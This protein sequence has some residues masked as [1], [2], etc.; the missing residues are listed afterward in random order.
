[1]EHKR[2][3]KERRIGGNYEEIGK[4]FGIN[5]MIARIMR[6]RGLETEEQMQNFLSGNLDTLGDPHLLTDADS[7][8]ELIEQQ[9]CM[10]K[11]I[12][13]IGDYDIDGVMSS[14]ILVKGL[15]RVGANVSV[16]IPHRINDGYG[17]N[18]HLIEEA[19]ADSVDCIITCDNGISAIEE[20]AMA[21]EYGMTVVVTDHH[22]VTLGIPNADAV[23]NPHRPDDA[24]PFKE[25]CGATVAWKVLSIV[26]ERFGIP[27]DEIND[28]IE[29]VGFATVGDIMPLKGENRV[30]VK[31]ALKAICNTKNL[32][33]RALIHQCELTDKEIKAYHFGFVLGPCINATGRLDTASRALE[34]FLTDN[35]ITATKIASELVTMNEERKDMTNEGVEEAIRIYEE[36]DYDRDPVLVLYLE[37]VHE[38]IAGIIAGRIRERYYRPTFILTKGEESIKG[39]ARSID[40]YSLSEEMAKHKD[41]FLKFG[42][43]P[44][45][46]GLSIE[47]S[48]IEEFRRVINEDCPISVD[49]ETEVVMLD[50]C[51]DLRYVTVDF[52]NQLS[53]LEPFGNE[54]SGPLFGAHQLSVDG[55]RI[56]GKNRNVIKL[57]L[58]DK[59]GVTVDGISFTQADQLLTFLREKFGDSEVEKA[60]KGNANSIS[61]SV[62]YSPKINDYNGPHVQLEI[63]Y[64]L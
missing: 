41:L 31:A 1:M 44:K 58:R 15:Q 64:Y 28:F 39:S 57:M 38:S 53:V 4:K 6:N 56:M 61:L 23:V 55:I 13:V 30:M 34:L 20:I 22:Q 45:A 48:R 47:E 3:F 52:V 7:A 25:I 8:A 36:G 32:G 5:P 12:R 42:G 21:K 18:S 33:M 62:I 40:E 35:P 10:G 29:Y 43:H 24:Y 49:D 26:Y 19:K 54:N 63:K 51:P 16:Q 37:N 2:I 17:L 60:L 46:A 27:K 11:H 59:E 50:A 14:F 9:I